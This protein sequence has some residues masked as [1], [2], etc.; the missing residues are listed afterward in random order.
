MAA[1]MS[2]RSFRLLTDKVLP[3]IASEDGYPT[4]VTNSQ[5]SISG[6]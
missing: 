1:P 4:M 3:R 6:M 2:G 5:I